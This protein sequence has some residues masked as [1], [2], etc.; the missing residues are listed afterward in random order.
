MQY[1]KKAILLF[2][3]SLGQAEFNA[4]CIEFFTDLNSKTDL[5]NHYQIW[6]ATTCDLKKRKTK[7]FGPCYMMQTTSY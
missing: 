4:Y 3:D 2:S 1:N 6:H 7:L 5:S